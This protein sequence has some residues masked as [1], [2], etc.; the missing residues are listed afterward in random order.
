MTLTTILFLPSNLTN[1]TTPFK[2]TNKENNNSTESFRCRFPI[3]IRGPDSDYDGPIP[4]TAADPVSD[5]GP[6]RSIYRSE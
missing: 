2:R 4:I 6:E 1:I 5:S 3:P